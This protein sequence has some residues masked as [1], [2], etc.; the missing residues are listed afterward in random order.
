M[1]LNDFVFINLII[2]NFIEISMNIFK[3][4]IKY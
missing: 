3:T 4:F 2:S 1:N